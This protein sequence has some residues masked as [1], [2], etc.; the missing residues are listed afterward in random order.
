MSPDIVQALVKTIELKD[1]STAA[2]TWRVVLYTRA[3]AEEAGLGRGEIERLSYA[4]A[5]HDVG[6]IDI[7]DE[8]L[9]KPGALTAQEYGVVK[10]HAALGHERLLRMGETDPLM[11]ELVRHHHER[12]DGKGYPDGLAGEQIATGAR[13]FSVI[14]AFDA[15]TSVRPYRSEVGPAAAQKAID[16]LQS[17]RGTRYWPRAVDMFASLYKTGKLGWI[18]DYFND[19]CPVEFEAGEKGA[20]VI[21]EVK[22]AG[23]GV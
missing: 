17:G 20:S 18:L 16:E 6:K 13:F 8:L 7:P 3:M 5:L 9:Q 23:S 12:W 14:D 2:H 11:L 19:R 1:R 4:A 22:G 21:S 15:M 10:T